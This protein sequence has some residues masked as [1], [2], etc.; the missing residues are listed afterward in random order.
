MKN[1]N[2]NSAKIAIVNTNVKNAEKKIEDK[3]IEG[4]AKINISKF[5]DQLSKIEL[6]EKKDKETIYVYPGGSDKEWIGSTKGKKFRNSLR[7]LMHKHANNILI[8]AK[9]N[10]MEK[11][12]EEIKKFDDFYKK[13]YRINDL[14]LKS[15]SS[16][17][18]PL[19]ERDFSLMIEIIK[20]VKGSK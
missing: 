11:L 8:F 5:S 10:Q 14:S 1:S 12:Q 3:K 15:I 20:E 6:K 19:K 13:N 16:S 2:Q 7:N 9:S 4:I 18:D 17:S